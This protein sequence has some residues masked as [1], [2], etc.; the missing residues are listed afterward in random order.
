MKIADRYL[1]REHLAPFFFALAVTTFILLMDKL[2]ELIDLLIGKR[3]T[4][5]VV[6]KIFA[7]S[8]PSILA[9]TVPMAVL[10]AVL[11]TF[12][13]ISG[14]NE[15]TA[16][17]SAGLP[18]ARLLLAPVL[19]SIILTIGLYFFTD[20]VLPEANHSLK[21]TFMAIS[22][23]KPTLRL[24][25]NT[26]V[27][28]F[29]G[30]NI[31]VGK[32]DAGNSRLHKIT[33]YESVPNGYPRTI[34]A[35]EGQLTMMSKQNVLRLELWRGQ[36]H[37]AD[38][39]DPRTY[40]KMDFNTH[41]I[42][43]PLDPATVQTV[44][45]QRGDREMTSQMMRAQIAQIEQTIAPVKTQLADSARLSFWQKEQFKQDI[46]NKTSDIRRYQVEV[47][48]KLAIPFACLVFVFL[49]APLGA[50]TRRGSMGASIGLALGFFVLY[51]LALVGG[52]E[53]ADRQIMSPWLAM[54]AANIILGTCGSL[55]LLWQNSEIDLRKLIPKKAI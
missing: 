49:G 8:L 20:R 40:H 52:E 29:T 31:L 2:F 26:F 37:E 6:F 44:R 3:V 30:Y 51:Y 45:A 36:I 18:L 14:D 41:V 28:D 42:N 10:V 15:L 5:L 17:K 32:V 50:L 24:K 34:I 55:L 33:I 9:L 38:A 48:K 7:L 11:M 4:G 16:L 19:A 21:N 47:Q 23:A 43:L 13:R 53:L 35:D 54:W 25:E 46:H 12:G 39:S 1:L 27:S 22:S